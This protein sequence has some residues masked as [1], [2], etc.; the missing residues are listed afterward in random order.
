MM[1]IANDNLIHF[2]I[3]IHLSNKANIDPDTVFGGN[4]PAVNLTEVFPQSKHAKTV[5]ERGS[6]AGL[7][8]G[9]LC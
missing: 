9:E 8:P 4:M 7:E 6:M 1:Y 2:Q 5:M 3:I